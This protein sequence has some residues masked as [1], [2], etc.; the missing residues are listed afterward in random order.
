MYAALNSGSAATFTPT[1]FIVA[2]DR[3]P[4]SD[5]PTATSSATFSFGAHSVSTP[6]SFA[7]ASR[8]SVLGVPG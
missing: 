7:R 1:C 6:S 5:A 4:P 3:A 8:I 2:S